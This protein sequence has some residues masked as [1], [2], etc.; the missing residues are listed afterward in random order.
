MAKKYPTAKLPLGDTN[1]I[2][3]RISARTKVAITQ[4]PSGVKT[5]VN[6]V[7]ITPNM[8]C[9]T[10]ITAAPDPSLSS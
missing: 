5:P 4:K 9:K 2:T 3:K 7:A 6:T 10:P 8:R 1:Q